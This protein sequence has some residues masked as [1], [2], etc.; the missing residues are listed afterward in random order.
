M[1]STMATSS[2]TPGG[3]SSRRSW[4]TCRSPALPPTRQHQFLRSHARSDRAARRILATDPAR[5][6]T[7]W[8]ARP[9]SDAGSSATCRL[10]HIAKGVRRVRRQ[11]QHAAIG[12]RQRRIDGERRGARGLSDAALAAEED[13]RGS[14]GHQGGSSST[15]WVVAARGATRRRRRPAGGGGANSSL[16]REVTRHGGQRTG[17]LAARPRWRA[18]KR[19]SR[20]CRAD[21][22]ARPAAPCVRGGAGRHTSRRDVA[23]AASSCSRSRGRP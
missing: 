22:A 19:W 16:R 21:A 15:P 20:R 2:S 8:P 10:Q 14:R 17:R 13:E 23:A 9:G 12:R 4:S 1:T 5:G 7:G 11:Q 18:P 6:P 3:A